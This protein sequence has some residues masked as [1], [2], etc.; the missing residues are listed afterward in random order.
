M[1][2][3]T[4]IF[5][6]VAQSQ[7]FNSTLAAAKNAIGG[8]GGKLGDGLK[9]QVGKIF[10]VNQGFQMMKGTMEEVLNRAKQYNNLGARMGI[11]ATEV[12]KLDKI[13][14]QAG[15]N[16]SALQRGMMLVGKFG[17]E[18]ADGSNKRFASFAKQLKATDADMKVMAAGGRD[19]MIKLAELMDQIGD[20]SDRDYIGLKIFGEKW[21][22]IMQ[23]IDDGGRKI[24]NGAD[25][26]AVWGDSTQ[27]SLSRSQRAWANMW[28]DISVLG[29]QL[30]DFF[31]PI[32]GILRII[33][34]LVMVIIRF[35]VMVFTMIKNVIQ[36]FVKGIVAGIANIFS[37]GNAKNLAKQ[38]WKGLKSNSDDFFL[39]AKNSFA[40]LGG[41]WKGVKQ[42][43]AFEM[44][45]EMDGGVDAEGRPLPPRPTDTRSAEERVAYEEALEAERE[46]AL[47]VA[48]TNAKEEEKLD[49]LK[50]QL[51]ILREQ[52]E[53]LKK[54][55]PDKYKETKEYL[56]LNA[57]LQ[58][59]NRKISD[60][61]RKDEKRLY[62][63]RVEMSE[64]A[65][66]RRLKKMEEAGATEEEIFAETV[67]QQ[68]ET[69]VRLS[70]ELARLD[71]DASATQEEKHKKAMELAKAIAK[72]EDTLYSQRKKDKEA[73]NLGSTAV[74][75]SLQ[76]VGGGGAVA[77]VST[78]AKQLMEAEETNRLLGELVTLSEK[79]ATGTVNAG[80]YGKP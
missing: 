78:A 35:I 7:G 23:L 75:S 42:V 53:E 59:Q 22:E 27:E 38:F 49:I 21:P 36:L 67:R 31:E 15:V 43:F 20:K 76:K 26:V 69:A 12:Q 1:S 25:G 50:K 65:N 24:K 17:K 6:L 56:E 60:Q 66:E 37:T 32:I 30:L 28:N 52:E 61:Q 79:I 73:A 41:M 9:A 11:P 72:T 33:L 70:E 45:D 10:S 2:N 55:H 40:D 46:K 44:G 4:A 29:A 51:E 58:E 3:F 19:G 14:E 48:L 74:V 77:V 64:F 68:K 18:A 8:L 57:K 71:A 16:V 34:N 5:R 54:K 63:Q 13:A 47:A 62:D 80:T 39:W